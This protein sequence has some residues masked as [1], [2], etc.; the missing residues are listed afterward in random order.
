MPG[1]QVVETP[2]GKTSPFCL[3]L[4]CH[5]HP[6]SHHCDMLLTEWPQGHSTML[7]LPQR[8]PVDQ[9][10][11]KLLAQLAQDKERVLS[12]NTGSC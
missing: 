7:T 12:M 11:K 4:S 2:G 5:P 6:H 8:D 1:P 3:W 10:C 9:P